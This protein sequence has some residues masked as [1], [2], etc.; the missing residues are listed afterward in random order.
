MTLRLK[1]NNQHLAALSVNC[2][3]YDNKLGANEGER[4]KA[5][6]TKDLHFTAANSPQP[7][8]A[9]VISPE[10]TDGLSCCISVVLF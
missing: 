9:T 3:F 7:L 1:T 6:K 10:R 4:R 5:K 2:R 8:P